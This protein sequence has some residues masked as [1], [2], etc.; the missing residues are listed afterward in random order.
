MADPILYV[1][2]EDLEA[3][4]SPATVL[5]LF[6][7][8]NTGVVDAA[9][10]R[11]TLV[12]GR[13]E[14]DGYLATVFEGPFPVPQAVTVVPGIIRNATLDFVIAFSF[15]RHPEYVQTYG[16]NYRAASRFERA[17]EMMRRIVAGEIRIPDW[18]LQP[19]GGANIGG[20]SDAG[21][22]R[23]ITPDPDGTNNQGDF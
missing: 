13:D 15:E 2:Q 23:I 20:Q 9:R 10:L 4:L 22:A 19:K 1:K 5:Q 7:D 3:A 14:V 17:R 16:E 18:V 6:N 12:R 21:G 11:A 8:N